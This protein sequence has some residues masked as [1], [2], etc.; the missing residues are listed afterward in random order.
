MIKDFHGVS[1]LFPQVLLISKNSAPT[2]QWGV[3]CCLARL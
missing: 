2:I 3:D 1:V